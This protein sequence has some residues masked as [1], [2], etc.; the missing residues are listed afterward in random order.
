MKI[1]LDAEVAPLAPAEVKFHPPAFIIHEGQKHDPTPGHGEI[2]PPVRVAGLRGIPTAA[3]GFLV[4]D[5]DDIE[6]EI[7]EGIAKIPFHL[8]QGIGGF[9]PRRRNGIFDITQPPDG[10]DFVIPMNGW[11]VGLGRH[12]HAVPFGCGLQ[13]VLIGGGA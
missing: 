8:A 11:R 6:T 5:P 1:E 3:D 12:D 7:G 10:I 2:P 4:C 13:F 9:I